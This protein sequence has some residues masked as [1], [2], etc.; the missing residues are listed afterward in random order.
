MRHYF[1]IRSSTHAFDDDKGQMLDT[2][3]AAA[4]RAKAI[5]NELSQHPLSYDGY[6]V[7]AVNKSGKTVAAVLIAGHPRW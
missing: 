2:V 3:Q 1:H 6:S 4:V 5:A 7:V